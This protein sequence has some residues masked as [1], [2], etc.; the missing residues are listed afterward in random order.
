MPIWSVTPL[1]TP[2]MPSVPNCCCSKGPAR[3]GLN[4]HLYSA[5]IV[6]RSIVINSF[7]CASVCLFNPIQC[8]LF[9]IAAV[10]PYWSNTPFYSAHVGCGV[11]A[12]VFLCVCELISGTAGP[13]ET[14]TRFCVQIS[15]SRGSV[16][17]R[18]RCAKLCT[19]GFMDDVTFGLNERDA[20]RWRLHSMTWRYRGGVR[21]LQMRVNFDIRALWRSVLSQK[22]K[23]WG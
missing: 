8:Q 14:A 15:C 20:Q 11:C 12:S 23:M 7:V 10:R 4:H 22:L 13:T 3:T 18:R 21:C 17:L 2:S 5:P 16:L 19:S 6:V 9:Q 1:L